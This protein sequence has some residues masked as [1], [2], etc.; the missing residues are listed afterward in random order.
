MIQQA[1]QK[2]WPQANRAIV[3][4]MISEFAYEQAFQFQVSEDGFI[5]NLDHGVSYRF[6]GKANIWGQV[7]IDPQTV[8]RIPDTGSLLATQ[9]MM[10]IQSL[11]NIPDEALAEHF[12][13][14][15]ATLLGDCKLAEKK[16][17]MTVKDLV[18]LSCELQQTYFDGHP[19]F[20]FN[21]GRRGWGTDDLDLYAPESQ[22]AFQL[23]WVAV[24]HS[25]LQKSTNART[26]WQELVDSAVSEAE[27]AKLGRVLAQCEVEQQD[28]TLVPVHPWQWSQ[29]L[30]LL[31]VREMADKSLLY[32]GEFGD[33]FLPQLSIRTLSNV[34]RPQ[35]Y[36]IKLPLT[37][38]N[39]SCY[40][41]I[42]GRYILA[43]PLASDW[44]DQVFKND[45]LLLGKEAEVL[46]EPASAYAAQADYKLLEKAPYRYHELLGV[47]WRESLASKLRTNESAILMAALMESDSQG[48]PLIGEYIAAS[49]L[50]VEAWLTKL[51]DAVV[52]PFYH[53]L[54]KYGVSLIA[55]GQ[56]ITI[57]MENFAPKRILLKDFQGDMRLVERDLPEQDSL[58]PMVKAVTVR[59]PEELII[60]DLQTG[61]FV[62]VLR[63]ISPLVE[64]LGFT[65]QQ[66]Y[67]LL[68]DRIGEHI[69]QHPELEERY[70]RLD[71]FKPRILRIGLNLA[72]FRHSTDSSASRMLPDMDDMLDNPLVLAR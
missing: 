66:F 37:I 52:I 6:E 59:L 25:I 54:T 1:L 16:Q 17:A 36:D 3:A 72:K 64:K 65:E 8:T 68:G 45:P 2:Y 13:D 20:A 56:N 14:L 60:H 33:Y 42:P 28:Y 57:V 32:L 23:G 49:G 41:G 5:L 24:H 46:Q 62:T 67:R 58:D 71:L 9:F 43:G 53:L 40:R 39:T 63:F 10:D 18:S 50:S 38:M 35:G 27:Q 4:K 55:H 12:E 15:N 7:V 34:S 44:I 70:E 31:F 69:S 29:K 22:R 11:L 21:K 26:H 51:F 19:K 48:N 47:I 30:S 61:H